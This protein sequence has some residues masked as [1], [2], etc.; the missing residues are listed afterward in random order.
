MLPVTGHD[1]HA[2]HLN[3]VL[4]TPDQLPVHLPR[5][6][7]PNAPALGLAE[8]VLQDAAA[9]VGLLQLQPQLLQL[10]HL[11]LLEHVS[12]LQHLAAKLL[13]LILQQT[14]QE[15]AGDG[16]GTW[17]VH[18][19]FLMNIVSG[20]TNNLPSNLQ[21]LTHWPPVCTITQKTFDFDFDM[22]LRR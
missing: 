18:T 11:L 4:Q 14:T 7:H 1:A 20:D 8:A 13:H 22:I 17:F 21:K 9:F 2:A 15:S 5:L 12:H 16:G 3:V 6:S 19:L 10:V